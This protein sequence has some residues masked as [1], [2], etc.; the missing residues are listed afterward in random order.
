[1]CSERCSEICSEM[2]GGFVCSAKGTAS[3][4]AEKTSGGLVAARFFS[5]GFET[6]CA[7]GGSATRPA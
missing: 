2:F 5:S 1:M 3:F 4:P 7:R 6:Y